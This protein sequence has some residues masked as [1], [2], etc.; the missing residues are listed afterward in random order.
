L[1]HYFWHEKARIELACGSHPHVD[2]HLIERRLKELIWKEQDRLESRGL[3]PSLPDDLVDKLKELAEKQGKEIAFSEGW[4]DFSSAAKKKDPDYWNKNPGESDDRRFN[5]E[6]G[7]YW[8]ESSKE[9]VDA[10]NKGEDV[11]LS[12]GSILWDLFDG[13]AN[14]VNDQDNDG[15]SIDFKYIWCA[16]NEKKDK[17]G[18]VIRSAP[19]NIKEFY[20]N[21]IECLDEAGVDYDREKLDGIFQAHG[22]TP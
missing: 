8:K 4:A 15:V 2:E 6:N 11:E 21:L 13:S 20:R 3:P 18:N 1:D 17:K 14:G 12:V 22:V 19:R 7:N 5:L 16:I 10:A 9:W